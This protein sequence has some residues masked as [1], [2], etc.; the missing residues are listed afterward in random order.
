MTNR[1]ATLRLH[2]DDNV[3][4]AV[5]ELAEGES[6]G[7]GN[8]AARQRV[9]R[10]HKVATAT[11]AKG[12]TVRKYNQIIGFAS[13]DVTPGQHVH[14][15]NLEF[16]QLAR[17]HAIGANA[18]DTAFVPA[19]QQAT[20]DGIVR[21]DGRVATRNFVGV[22]T[23]VNCSATVAELHQRPVPRGP[24]GSPTTPTSTASSR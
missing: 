18:R 8:L 5:R 17:D 7:E 22:L 12:E 2:A 4:T 13:T 15:Q 1:S 11:V 14:T 6:L 3:V 20:F 24:A 10:G 16:R 23:T 21:P 19:D 9:P